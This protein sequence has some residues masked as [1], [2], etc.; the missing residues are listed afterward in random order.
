[1]TEK[2]NSSSV[3]KVWVK[4]NFV[5]GCNDGAD[6]QEEGVEVIYIYIYLYVYTYRTFP[7]SELGE[8][9]MT[10]SICFQAL[11]FGHP[12]ALQKFDKND[13]I[14][15]SITGHRIAPDK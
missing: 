13:R 15:T 4:G 7:V 12:V 8:V 14:P 2:T 3:P 10:H 9:S 6:P 1:M 11:P 5:G